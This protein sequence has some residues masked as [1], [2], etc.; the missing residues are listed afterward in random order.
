VQEKNE[1]EIAEI[2]IEFLN[3]HKNNSALFAGAGVGS[4][5]GLMDW[6]SYLAYLAQIPIKY[7]DDLTT[8]M[9]LKRIEEKNYS[10]AAE[11]Y[12]LSNQIPEGEKF[13]SLSRPFENPPNEKNLTSLVSLPF[14]VFFTTNY[15][16]ALHNAYASIVHKSP[17]QVELFDESMKSAVMK[18]QFYIARIHGR[19]E[20]PNSI[21]ISNGDFQR[22]RNYD[23]YNDLLTHSFTELGWIFVGYSFLD[24]ALSH[25]LNSIKER[26]SPNYPS[27]H[28]ALLPNNASP[29]LLSKLNSL[30]ISPIYYNP[31]NGHKILW[32]GIKIASKGFSQSEKIEKK[33]IVLPLNSIQSFLAMT[34]AKLKNRQNIN[35]LREIV[36]DGII[37]DLLSRK[38]QEGMDLNDLSLE[39]QKILRLPIEK[40]KKVI[41]SRVN[42]PENRDLYE[43]IETNIKVKS[44]RKNQIEIDLTQLSNSVI[45]RLIVRN[46]YKLDPL[47][48][49]AINKCIEEIFIQRGWDLG[50][51]YLG[52]SDCESM[53]LSGTIRKVV[54][55][56]LIS[57]SSS[58]QQ[59]ICNNI[60]D[61]FI[62]P[63]SKDSVILSYLAR[64]SFAL[65]LVINT[66]TSV[67]NQKN[68]LPESLYLD[69]N[70]LMPLIVEGH[71][72]NAAY[73]DTL[74]TIQEASK[75]ARNQFKII[76][77]EGFLNEVI[78][79]RKISIIE[80]AD[81]EL[82]DPDELE[83]YIRLNRAENVNVFIG[84][85]S[86]FVGRIKNP[87]SFD[88]FLAEYAPYTTIKELVN[89]LQ[90]LNICPLEIKDV[91]KAQEYSQKYYP[92]L[93]DYYTANKHPLG[94]MKNDVLIRHETDQL[95]ILQSDIDQNIRS[96]FVTAD[97][98][99]QRTGTTENFTEIGNSILSHIGLIQFVDLIVGV[100]VDTTSMSRLMWGLFDQSAESNMI[101]YFTSLALKDYDEA[102]ALLLPQILDK[103]L[104]QIQEAAKSEGVRLLPGG[105]FESKSRTAKFLDRFEDDFYVYMAEAMKN[106]SN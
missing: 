87:M 68:L 30:N 93:K 79:H 63:D 55:Q 43:I 100:N 39:L 57:L 56:N 60:E 65:Q 78:S 85:Y 86:S 29:E 62:N 44:L 88:H 9:M 59:I 92:L 40:C 5:A 71:P 95:A 48:F 16:R 4:Q 13:Q 17:I 47:L 89:Y 46:S 64:V 82:E 81:L 99:L 67:I 50:A 6:H 83:N 98:I 51:S 66:P 53:E 77:Y 75:K 8:Q 74:E 73:V 54:N 34:Y 25:V 24:P 84:A 52:A 70:F 23:P 11:Y 27:N 90:S 102:K 15:D 37:E 36:V 101:N 19:V 42:L 104:P 106:F 69:S 80:V 35:P 76:V 18:K 14:N 41:E 91:P 10:L 45:N 28:L 49:P 103:L 105:S 1:N 58:A 12:K 33:P 3:N 72:F 21:I 7:G 20:V 94:H 96:I 31:E 97:T 61:L 32:D 22:L 26:I 2:I 38:F